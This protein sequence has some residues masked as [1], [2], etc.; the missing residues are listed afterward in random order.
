MT[1]TDHAIYLAAYGRRR[2]KDDIYDVMRKIMQRN[3]KATMSQVLEIYARTVVKDEGL[4]RDFIEAFSGDVY[5]AIIRKPK[6][7]KKHKKARRVSAAK[8]IMELDLVIHGEFK[9]LRNCTFAEIS[10]LGG[11][12]TKLGS[13]GPPEAIV[14]DVLK[15]KQ[16]RAALLD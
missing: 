10:E 11:R 6:A 13:M 14:G 7:S 5:R 8:F 4:T 1:N 12:Y 9:R 3:P 16:V 15:P 2:M